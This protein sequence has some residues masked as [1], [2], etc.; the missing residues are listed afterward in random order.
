MT[1]AILGGPPDRFVS[2]TNLYRQSASAAGHDPGKTQLA[3]NVHFHIADDA[4]QAANDFYPTY[5]RMMT[6]VGRE[7]GWSPMTRQQFEYL[8]S[9]GPLIVTDADE[10][11]EKIVYLHSIFKNTRFLAQLISGDIP[12]EKIMRSIE[13]FGTKVAPEVRKRIR[14][15]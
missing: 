9:E 12:H 13:L 7:R 2:F 5:E 10:A 8:R 1:V 6:R 11:V 4:E 14:K 15:R 3:V